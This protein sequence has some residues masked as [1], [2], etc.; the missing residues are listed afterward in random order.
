MLIN[1]TQV[2]KKYE[3]VE[4]LHSKLVAKFPSV[5]FPSQPKMSLI[6]TEKT[7][8]ERK[9]F[10]EQLMK[11]VAQTPKLCSSSPVLSFLEV[12]TISIKQNKLSQPEPGKLKVCGNEDFLS[13]V[14]QAISDIN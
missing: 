6:I 4:E 13:N 5:K 12:G 2:A 3:E 11:L 8:N 1:F 9:A 10:L 7:L 14:K